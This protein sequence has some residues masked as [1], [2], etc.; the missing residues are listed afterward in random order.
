MEYYTDETKNIIGDWYK[1]DID[2]WGFE[3]ETGAQRN[4][5]NV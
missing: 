2:Y 5:W 1:D 3:F 4:Y